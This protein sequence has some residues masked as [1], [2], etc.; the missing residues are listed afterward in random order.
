[1]SDQ[2]LNSAAAKRPR[3]S[4]DDDPKAKRKPPSSHVRSEET[5]GVDELLSSEEVSLL[6][7]KDVNIQ[8]SLPAQSSS[9]EQTT[10]SP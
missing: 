3:A 8:V 4:P 1:M 10:A 5:R 7:A 2:D 6:G 9:S